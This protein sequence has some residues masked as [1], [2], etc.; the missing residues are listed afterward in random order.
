MARTP[1]KGVGKRGNKGTK[2]GKAAVGNQ[3]EGGAADSDRTGLQPSI[4]CTPSA[5]RPPAVDDVA[6]DDVAGDDVAVGDVVPGD[7][8]PTE[9][10][11]MPTQIYPDELSP[12]PESGAQTLDLECATPVQLQQQFEESAL[13]VEEVPPTGGTNPDSSTAV[14]HVGGGQQTMESV[15]QP[16]LKL[17]LGLDSTIQDEQSVTAWRNSVIPER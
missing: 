1:P 9:F 12:Y 14:E 8:A 6:G 10:A 7:V 2:K 3:T 5:R 13:E 4:D 17:V 11:E 15:T 16:P